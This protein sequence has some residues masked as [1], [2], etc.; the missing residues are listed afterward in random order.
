ML[1]FA[2]SSPRNPCANGRP[3]MLIDSGKSG[4]VRKGR[5][6]SSGLP[7]SAGISGESGGAPSPLRRIRPIITALRPVLTNSRRVDINLLG[8]ALQLC[9]GFATSLQ[10]KARSEKAAGCLETCWWLVGL[11]AVAPV[12]DHLHEVIDVHDAVVVD[13][14]RSAL[15]AEVA[16]HHH[17]VINVHHAIG[18][19]GGRDV[20]RARLNQ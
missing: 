18:L 2:K 17:Q 4:T 5:D 15:G 3:W 7:G 12:D 16:D 14:R 11:S 20:G 10:E 6:G 9:H 1:W 13:V 19:A 8:S